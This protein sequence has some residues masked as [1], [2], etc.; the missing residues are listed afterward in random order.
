MCQVDGNRSTHHHTLCPHVLKTQWSPVCAARILF[1][2]WSTVHLPRATLLKKTIFQ[3]TISW[4][5]SPPLGVRLHAHL[6]FPLCAGV[7]SSLSWHKS[8]VCCLNYCEYIG[9]I[10]LQCLKNIVSLWL[11]TVS[12]ICCFSATKPSE[13]GCSIYGQ[14]GAQHFAVS[15][16]LHFGQWW[17]LFVAPVQKKLVRAEVCSN[18]WV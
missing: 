8:C 3:T 6:S 15:Y 18:L 16:S 13:E 11:S 14:F 7:L 2:L 5:I 10:A 1:N 12:Y 9:I 4:P 17:F